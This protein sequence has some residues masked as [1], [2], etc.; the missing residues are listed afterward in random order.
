VVAP[1]MPRV[2]PLLTLLTSPALHRLLP[3][4]VAALVGQ[5]HGLTVWLTRP[6][7]RARARATMEAI[8]GGTS[9]AH[10][11]HALARRHITE[12]FAVRMI[13]WQPPATA[14]I[15]EESRANLLAALS[16]GRGVLL[17]C[18]HLGP[19]FDVATPVLSVGRRSFSAS[20]NWFFDPPSADYGGRR[21][22]HWWRRVATR[23]TY[24]IRA[25]R[26][27]PTIQ[28]LLEE[29]EIVVIYF[30]MIG[31]RETVL[32]G[33]PMPLASGTARLATSAGAL[34]LPVR[35]RRV[36]GRVCVDILAPLDPGAFAEP[37]QLHDALATIHS[38]LIL[39]FPETL[40]DPRRPGAWEE[41]ATAEAWIAPERAGSAHK[42]ADEADATAT[43][44]RELR[45]C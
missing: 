10:E 13:F 34:V 16:S 38:K 30:D 33:K 32:L 23:G 43:S 36:G 4:R 3:R 19:F 31:S 1:P 39:E 20:G 26:S 25:N 8:V 41:G 29:G 24:L 37:G 22:A 7:A 45:A 6:R 9:R 11:A 21:V 42:S 28:V 40:E 15:D 17:S 18:C 27:Y 2:G 44:G 14:S 12:K 5:A 35:A